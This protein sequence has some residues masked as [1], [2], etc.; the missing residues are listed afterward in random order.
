MFQQF[1]LL[2]YDGVDRLKENEFCE[3][4]SLFFLLG[5]VYGFFEVFEKFYLIYN[6]VM[7]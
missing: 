4:K 7:V 1:F 2:F 6:F 3:M 5:Y